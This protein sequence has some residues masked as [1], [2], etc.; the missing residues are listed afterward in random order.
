MSGLPFDADRLSPQGKQIYEM[1]VAKRK[2][3]GAPFDGP[4]AVLMN[5]P[6]LCEKVEALGCFLK[7]EGE[8][9]RSV[10]QF[11]VLA[12]AKETGAIFEWNDPL[13]H[14]EK[15]GI[16]SE[17]IS[18]LKAEGV[19]ALFPSSYKEAVSLLTYTLHWKSIPKEVQQVA[20]QEF[21]VR[22]LLEIVVLSD[23]YRH[24]AAI[25]QG[26]DVQH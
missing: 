16:P 4:Y 1:L 9:N 6:L 25:N 11:V 24:F 5:H 14:A 17:V 15:A 26:F 18:L 19:N 10:Y 7:F 22:G 8:L 2:K 3:Q 21:A 12:V 23:V 20:I 13:P